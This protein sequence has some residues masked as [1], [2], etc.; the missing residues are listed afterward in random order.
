MSLL[1]NILL[2]FDYTAIDHQI[3]KFRQLALEY[4]K[5]NIAYYGEY[6]SSIL[7]DE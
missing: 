2:P 4:K 3:D 6:L 7:F 1:E 5:V